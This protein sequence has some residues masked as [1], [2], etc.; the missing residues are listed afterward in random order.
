MRVICSACGCSLEVE[1]GVVPARV[2][3]PDCGKR[4][5]LQKHLPAG[6]ALAALDVGPAATSPP[7][8]RP[9][10]RNLS[11]AMPTLVAGCL[12]AVVVAV[13][14][15][16]T[17]SPTD[18]PTPSHAP[19]AATTS[20]PSHRDELIAMERAADALAGRGDVQGAYDGYVRLLAVAADS[21]TSSDPAAAAVVADARAA[22]Q[23]ALDALVENRSSRT[24]TARS[25]SS[26]ASA[27]APTT[28]AT[29][30]DS[31]ASASR[32]ASSRPTLVATRPAEPP[33]ADDP[34]AAVRL[35]ADTAPPLANPPPPP[36]LHTYTLPDAISDAEIGDAID[37]AITWLRAHGGSA[38]VAAPRLGRLPFGFGQR[39]GGGGGRPVNPNDQLPGTGDDPGQLGNLPQQPSRA[40]GPRMV[41]GPELADTPVGYQVLATYAL[42]QA[43][44]STNKAGLGAR[45][46]A[47]VA[48][49][50]QLKQLDLRATYLRSL[51]A[52]TLAV[53]NRVEDRS[54]LEQDVRWLVTAQR[55]GGYTYGMPVGNDQSYDN[56]NSQYGLLGVW[57]GA[58]S[59]I[60]VGSNYWQ[61]VAQHWIACATPAGTWG[62]EANG[63]AP[64]L[65]MT[66]AGV[67]SLLV[68]HEYLDAAA[69]AS[70][71]ARPPARTPALD[72]GLNWLDQG[73]NA[74][75]GLGMMGS[76]T[77]A[78]YTVY[79]LERV[80]LASGYKYFGRHD[81][82]SE[83]ARRLIANQR[84]DGS[85]D[86]SVVDTAYYLLFLARG[87]HPILYNKLRYDGGWN[88]RPHDVANLARF[89]A[90]QLE[91][92]LN[93]QVVNLRRNWFDWMDAPV[94]YISGDRAPPLTEHDYGALRSFAEGGGLIFTHADGG[95]AAFT[96]W[97]REMVRRVFPKYE[98]MRVPKDHPLNTALY[99]LKDPPPLEVVNNGSRIVLV[100]CP[101][102]IAGGWQL[103]WLDERKA[104]FQ[105]GVNV[106][107][108]AAGKTNYQNRLASTYIPPWP[109]DPTVTRTVARLRFAG[110]WDPEPYAWTRFARYFT[111][112]AH[113]GLDVQTID[114]KQLQ[115]GQVPAA[116]LTGTVRQDFTAAEAAAAR[117][118]VE[119]GGVLVIDACGGRDA[120]TASARKLLDAAFPGAAVGPLPVNHPLFVASRPFADD[121]TKV[122]L[123]PFASEKLGTHDVPIDGLKFGHG[124]VVFS[125]LD[126]TTGLLGTQS[127]GI[128]GYDPAAAQALVKNAILWAGARSGNSR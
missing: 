42:I 115:P 97:V 17:R 76:G 63:S 87:R 102:D 80:G 29:E 23:R 74:V 124:W 82:Y 2:N 44:E 46:P 25:W 123:R 16:A 107:V 114:L 109:G 10:R 14:V 116:F 8:R 13:A 64:Y 68:S 112:E 37:R 122:P 111:W 39:R 75:S 69:E 7:R 6:D 128:L 126:L 77:Y 78:S 27:V 93:W 36:S 120:F 110:E 118:Y 57:S 62:Y 11:W 22:K 71:T 104:D 66:L 19:V 26:G 65:S 1:P 58:Q 86:E 18:R 121:L 99:P 33:I 9:P 24:S 60:S 41:V 40:N 3:C 34:A 28:A 53:Y 100:H 67:A 5:D 45:D 70:G 108:Y 81:W 117:A 15:V 105:L 89:A 52:A 20:Q 91:R 47:V 4:I 35:A 61:A 94:L 98:L 12:G 30:E 84:G 106:F 92:P 31:T 54:C 38:K 103:N 50:D 95:S 43:G 90:Q 119:A 48:A 21:G 56:S 49:L 83:F 96:V 59:G 72:H 85:W 113:A 101:T 55:R 88:N 79:G 32:S 51:R 127:W 73:D 125:R